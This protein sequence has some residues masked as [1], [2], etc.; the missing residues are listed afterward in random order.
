MASGDRY[1]LILNGTGLGRPSI[2][3]FYYKA[4]G[5]TA[6]AEDLAEAFVADVLPKIVAAL[7]AEYTAENIT[8]VNVDSAADFNFLTLTEDNI[9]LR[10]S[11][12]LPRFVAYTFQYVR[13]T[14]ASRHG[15]KRF[16]PAAEADVDDGVAVGT[17]ILTALV[18]L[19]NQLAANLSILGTTFT[20]VI[21]RRC[22]PG[23]DPCEV[24]NL[25][26]PITDVVYAHVGSQNSRK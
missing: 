7:S 4:S 1:N 14:R 6:V 3:S 12:A 20:P 11:E 26:F 19:E 5:G 22:E 25:D 16:G 21:F 13:A 24:V 18:N 2:N 23:S 17:T 9:G 8:T 10:P 15:W